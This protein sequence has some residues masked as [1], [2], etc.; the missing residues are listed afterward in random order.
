MGKLLDFIIIL[1]ILGIAGFLFIKFYEL[2]PQEK[3]DLNIFIKQAELPEANASSELEMFIP[4]MRFDTSQ[5]SYFF[6]DCDESKQQE[7]LKAF[8]EIS[9]KTKVITFYNA[10]SQENAKI[11]IFCSSEKQQKRNNTFVAGEGGPDSLINLSLYP[12]IESGQI[13]LY[14][15][16]YQEQCD[17]PVVELHELMH[18]FG[19]NHIE[20][21]SSILY[22]YVSCDQKI[23]DE[24]I[25]ELTKIYS[26]SA[27]ADLLIANA[28]A[29]KGGVYLNFQISTQNRGLIKAS[30]VELE[31]YDNSNNK[32][33]G[34]FSLRELE[35]G[36][37]ST[38][39]LQ[40]YMLPSRNTDNLKFKVKT[41][42]LEY[43]YENNEI[44]ASI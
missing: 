9:E 24:M 3:Q 37:T 1:I 16:K 23:T 43:F 5:L 2:S 30:N 4:N 21:K 41:S 13:Y 28:S 19:F 6:S 36:E 27:K 14:G 29:S 26:L 8:S 25:S 44:S 42:T 11:K 12:L 18:V 20:D 34:N 17:Y 22:P 35:P 31:I 40:N 32:K 39:T 33:I 38:I 15:L 7:M 10:D